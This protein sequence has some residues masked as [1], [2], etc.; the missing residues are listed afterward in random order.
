MW[1]WSKFCSRFCLRHDFA[2]NKLSSLEFDPLEEEQS[3]EVRPLKSLTH[4]FFKPFLHQCC[5]KSFLYHLLRQVFTD[6]SI[7]QWSIQDL[8]HHLLFHLHLNFLKHPSCACIELDLAFLPCTSSSSPL[9][10]A[11][12]IPQAPTMCLHCIGSSQRHLKKKNTC[13]Q[14]FYNTIDRLLVSVLILYRLFSFCIICS[15]VFLNVREGSFISWKPT[16]GLQ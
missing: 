1:W 16:N 9:P 11:P 7:W 13:W 5:F 3:D 12:E 14:G 10:S 4:C 15:H 2:Q 6:A 8:L